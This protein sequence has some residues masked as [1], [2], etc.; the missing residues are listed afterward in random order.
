VVEQSFIDGLLLKL[1][2][3]ENGTFIL[4][5]ATGNY[6][7]SQTELSFSLGPEKRTQSRKAK[8]LGIHL[9]DKMSDTDK[10]INA[11]QNAK[12][13]LFSLLHV[14]VKIDP[15]RLNQ[16]TL[17]SLIS[18]VP[19]YFTDV[20]YG[21]ILKSLIIEFQRLA[22]KKIRKCYIRT[23][24]DMCLSMIGWRNVECETDLRK[25]MFLCRLCNMPN[26]VLSYQVFNARLPQFV[27]S[28]EKRQKCFIPGVIE[29]LQK[30]TL[31]HHLVKYRQNGIFPC[32][33]IWKSLCKHSI[34]NYEHNNWTARINADDTFRRFKFLQT[35][36]NGQFYGNVQ[37]TQ[38]A[39]IMPT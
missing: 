33:H 18:K 34:R 17:A 21:V 6:S 39:Y 20:N 31:S 7:K 8:H 4:N 2:K 16:I 15:Y 28:V 10:V 25:L 5:N 1:E 29:I 3:F 26:S 19:G 38:N 9:N 13:S 36:L 24:T 35:T 32:H 14:S 23:R 37:K 30:Y 11:I 12:S 22:A 27:C